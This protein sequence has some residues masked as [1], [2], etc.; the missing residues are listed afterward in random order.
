MLQHLLSMK[1]RSNTLNK[2]KTILIGRKSQ[3]LQGVPTLVTGRI[4]AIFYIEGKTKEVI[5]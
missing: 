4:I 2:T 1:M 5:A 3:G